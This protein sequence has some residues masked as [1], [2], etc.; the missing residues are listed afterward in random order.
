MYTRIS[1]AY[2][3]N[4]VDKTQQEGACRS[5]GP[6]GNFTHISTL[7]PCFWSRAKVGKACVVETSGTVAVWTVWSSQTGAKQRGTAGYGEKSD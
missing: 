3:S 4:L 6:V 2:P 5:E 7:S 1:V